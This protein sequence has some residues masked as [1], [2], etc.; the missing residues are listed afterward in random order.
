MGDQTEPQRGPS[1]RCLDRALLEN[2][3]L[4]SLPRG[5]KNR[6]HESYRTAARAR[7]GSV[8][9]LAERAVR[10]GRRELTARLD[11]RLG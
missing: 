4:A 8:A 2:Y 7:S 5:C 6:R 11:Q 9:E 1:V 3:S 10:A